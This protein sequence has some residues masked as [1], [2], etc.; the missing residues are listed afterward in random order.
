MLPRLVLLLRSTLPPMVLI[1]TPY[2][3]DQSLARLANVPYELSHIRPEP[4]ASS[5]E[6]LATVTPEAEQEN[7]QMSASPQLDPAF[8]DLP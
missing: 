7:G 1:A 2:Y 4:P 8:V 3:E 5:P 6:Q